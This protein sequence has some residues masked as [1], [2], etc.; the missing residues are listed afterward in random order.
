MSKFS[1]GLATVLL[2][3]GLWSAAWGTTVL[4]L[5]LDQQ[6]QSADRIVRGRIEA[7]TNVQ[8]HSRGRTVPYTEV[9]V[10]ARETLKATA[11][12][13]VIFRI[14]GGSLPDGT[15]VRVHG[16]PSFKPGEEV[17][18]MLREGIP[19]D[20]PIVGFS[21]GCYRLKAD[22][23]VGMRVANSEGLPVTGLSSRG[24]VLRADRSA[25]D[26]ALSWNQFRQMIEERL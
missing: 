5:T 11:H 17:C 6:V 26:A 10:A 1:C 4:I 20:V 16:A 15:V 14:L 2:V 22:P 24:L 12:P 8:T 3:L 18:L 7:V 21:Q 25:A 9:R 13:V 23:V 19:L